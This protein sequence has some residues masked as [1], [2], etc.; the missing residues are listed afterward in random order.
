MKTKIIATIGPKSWDPKVFENILKNGAEIVRV[1]F[2]HAL[3]KD[4]LHIKKMVLDYNKKHKT[5]IKIMQDLQGPRIRMGDLPEEGIKLV[6][7]KNYCFYHQEDKEVKPN[8]CLPISD[9]YL[10]VDMKKGEPIYLV[11]GQMEV[12]VSKIKDGKIYFDV[13]RGGT[14]FSHKAINVPR[15]SLRQG[16]LTAKD[17]KDVK[18]ALKYGVDFIALSFVQSAED[19]IKLKKIIGK[20]KVKIVAKIERAVALDHL[21]AI[22]KQADVLMVARG[23]LGI[24][25][26]MEQVPIIQKEIIR[27]CHWHNTPAIVATQMMV[28]MV[29]HD[30]PTRAE[31][32]DVANAIFDGADAVMLSE[33]TANGQYSAEVVKEM[34]KV[35]DATEA[36]IK[37]QSLF[38][39]FSD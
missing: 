11:N 26:P 30:S 10:H 24:E 2:S 28:S 32:S 37:R 5:K 23:D 7:G 22:I 29:D 33:E 15:T 3:E 39:N 1:N 19:I 14:L 8:G 21:D 36:H 20:N 27:Q 6:V 35:V 17:I 25:V 12:E 16:G 4:F 18:F 9:P 34:K 13:I 31:V 38:E